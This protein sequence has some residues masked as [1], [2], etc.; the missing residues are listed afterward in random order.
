MKIRD[1]GEKLGIPAES[2]PPPNIS[3]PSQDTGDRPK[4]LRVRSLKW[5]LL[6]REDLIWPSTGLGNGK[7][8]STFSFGVYRWMESFA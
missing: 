7:A 5:H 6:E 4:R 3:C 2:R 1:G 8:E